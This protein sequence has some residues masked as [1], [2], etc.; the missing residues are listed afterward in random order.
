MEIVYSREGITQ[1]GVLGMSRYGLSQLCRRRVANTSQ[2][3]QI[4][5]D[6]ACRCDT[7]ERHGCPVYINYSR[8]VQISPNVQVP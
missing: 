1:G 2:C 3:R 7:E 6:I 5:A 4:L 8:Q